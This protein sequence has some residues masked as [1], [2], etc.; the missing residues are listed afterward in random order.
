MK[1]KEKRKLINYSVL[2]LGQEIRLPNDWAQKGP[3]GTTEILFNDEKAP[4][5]DKLR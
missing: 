5:G 4:L 3:S 1:K 2:A